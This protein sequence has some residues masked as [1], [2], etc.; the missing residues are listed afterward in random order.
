MPG[1]GLLPTSSAPRRAAPWR[2]FGLAF[3]AAAA[4]LGVAFG[5]N[6]VYRG[7]LAEHEA[8]IAR[9]GNEVATVDGKFALLQTNLEKQKL[10]KAST[11]K[12][13]LPPQVQIVGPSQVLP[14]A[15][16]ALHVTARDLD[17]KG[18][19]EKIQT[20]V[21]EAATGKVLHEQTDRV[22]GEGSIQ[23][24]GLGISGEPA[25]LT[26][27]PE[28]GQAVNGTIRVAEAV[29][30]SH[31][32]LNKSLY[33]VGDVLFFRAL[34]LERYSL[35]PAK[36]TLSLRFT[37]TDANGRIVKELPGQTGPGGISAGE[38]AL[39]P[40]LVSGSYTFQVSAAVGSSAGVVPQSTTIEIVRDDSP[41][42][43]FDRNQ[44]RAGDKINFS[45]TRGQQTGNN[46]A[47]STQPVTITLNADGQHVQQNNNANKAQT[48]VQSRPD[49]AGNISGEV[50]LPQRVEKA[51]IVA[52]FGAGDGKANKKVVQPIPVVPT[53]KTVDFFPEGGD[54][55]A[56]VSNRVYYRV[57]S[58]RGEPVDPD[59]HVIILASKEVL[60]DSERHQALGSFT[61]TP[62][63]K[64]KYS[65]RITGADSVTEI[66]D[67]FQK[68]GIKTDG[69]V[70]HA[71]EA[72]VQEGEPLKIVLRNPGP[73][74]RLWL[75]TVCRGQVVDQQYVESPRGNLDVKLQPVA[76]AAG[77]L[78]VTAL[79]GT[80]ARLVPIAERLLY[81]ARRSAWTLPARSPMGP[82][83]TPPA[84]R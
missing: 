39:T 14:G 40:E 54:L 10:E 28:R 31:L 17:G 16:L 59:G 80:G 53:E 23:V 19:A 1:P 60:H 37:L 61:F 4:V 12:R 72:V 11:L 46:S 21:K 78:R 45:F 56:G 6:E 9:I 27:V 62:D 49:N 75:Q 22:A 73:S 20:I 65:V 33:Y 67:P 47:Y 74:R 44:Y 64:E 29:Y 70:L 3:A 18:R 57:R 58:P 71:P 68:L 26:F 13:Q 36:E 8:D 51:E 63:P 25:A 32:A 42:F 48:S 84:P 77:V 76:G 30:V 83:R 81:R 35:T 50:Q 34:T 55:V 15:P 82:D 79:E 38:M 52:E 24:P 43:A 66:R 7:K 69:I 2:R 41:Q 5:L